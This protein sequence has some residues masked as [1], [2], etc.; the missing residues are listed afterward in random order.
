MAS[1]DIQYLSKNFDSIKSDLIDYIKRHFPNEISDFSDASGGMALIE[2]L[3]YIGDLSA[4]NVDRSINENFL[5]RAI[6]EKNVLSLAQ[7]RGY[8]PKFATPATVNLSVSATLVSSISS[9]SMFILK[10]GSRV[11]TSVEPITSFEITQDTDFSLTANRIATTT[12][13]NIMLTVSGISAVAGQ[14]R[15]FTYTAGSTPTPFLKITLPDED[16]SE[17]VSITGS[18]N[19]E[20]FEVDYLARDTIFWGELNTTSSSGSTPYVLKLK[21]VP[22]RFTVEKEIGGRCS[23]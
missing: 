1:R 20:W 15:S 14:T 22:K 2:L 13:S 16:I 18:D 10:K 6:E 19:S 7:G 12:G 23:I 21:K 5:L 8:K 4:F 11:V 3:A 9:E 17:I